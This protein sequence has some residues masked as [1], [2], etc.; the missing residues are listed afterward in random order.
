LSPPLPSSLAPIKLANPGSPGKC[1]LKWRE[2]LIM[3]HHHSVIK[4]VLQTDTQFVNELFI[5]IIIYI[6]FSEKLGIKL[7]KLNGNSC[8]N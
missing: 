4:T 7:R 6:E 2:I 1:P 5:N 3:V 8:P